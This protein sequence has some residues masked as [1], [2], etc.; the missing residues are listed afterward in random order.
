VQEIFLVYL[1]LNVY[2]RILFVVQAH[3]RT[4]HELG[5]VREFEGLHVERHAIE[6]PLKL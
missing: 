3:L 5:F 6:Q 4:Y 1:L 2:Y